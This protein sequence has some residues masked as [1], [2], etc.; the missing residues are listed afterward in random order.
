MSNTSK[1]YVQ[2]ARLSQQD[3]Q[4]GAFATF[5]LCTRGHVQT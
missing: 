4:A 2:E 3:M 5:A 1:H